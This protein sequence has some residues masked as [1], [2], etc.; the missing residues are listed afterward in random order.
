[1]DDIDREIQRTQIGKKDEILVNPYRKKEVNTS[2][3]YT[4]PPMDVNYHKWKKI[5]TSS[6][7]QPT[8]VEGST[9]SGSGWWFVGLVIL[10]GIGTKIM[11]FW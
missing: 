4:L 10:L 2:K 6:Y 11:G 5:K 9:G 3:S 8:R 1:M 7:C